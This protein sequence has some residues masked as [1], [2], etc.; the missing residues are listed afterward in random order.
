MVRTC[1]SA[2][3]EVIADAVINHMSGK[4]DGGVGFAGSPFS[5]YDYPGI[6]QQ[7]DFNTCRRD[8]AD[9]T[10]VWEVQ[11]C[12]LV[13]LA[14]LATGSDYVRGR[15][16]A[17]LNDLI[18]L[19]VGGFRI[20]AA[21]HIPAADIEAIKSRLTDQSVYIVQEVIGAAGEPV[22]DT[23]YTY[24]GDV[25]EFDYARDLKR[26]FTSEKL[27]Y[28]SNFGE[29]WGLITSDKAGVFVDNHDAE[30][31]GESLNQTYGSTYTLANVFMLT[32]P[33]GSPSVHSGYQMASTDAGA[34]QN[35]DG[36]VR[37][38][39][40]YTD[41]WT[42]QHDWRQIRN[43][44]AFHNAAGDAAVN[45]WWD[46][47]NNQ[48]AFG[49]G[50]SAYVAI[51]KESSTLS[52]T[53]TT[54]LVAG[55]YCDVIS[56]APTATGCSGTTVQVGTDGRF[57]ASVGANNAVAIHVDARAG[58][59]GVDTGQATVSFGVTATTTWGESIRVVGNVAALGAW[60]PA[61]GVALSSA[62]YPVW[63]GAVTLPAGTAVEYTYV[64]VDGSGNVT[65]ESGSNRVA[66]VPSSGTLTLNDTWR[67]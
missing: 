23:D 11:N 28:L 48:I 34:P 62:T 17:Y 57:T 7:Q 2:G 35:S 32:W 65:W 31:N 33:Y 13:S 63:R 61:S 53:F 30:R 1:P 41:G 29:A 59:G 5:Y 51:N 52:R 21:K 50:T 10:N 18:T 9:Y 45:Q 14:D 67:S 39:V 36:T 64:R 60:N 22:Q 49:R 44:V 8:I 55:S 25:H 12:N 16:A 26:V 4:V 15:I 20:D 37:D 24:I 19:G 42:C 6:Y 47:G 40:C 58:G 43:M 54:S 27:S 66:T 38:A 46:N 56:G 3:V